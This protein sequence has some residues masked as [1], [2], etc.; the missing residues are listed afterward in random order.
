MDSNVPASEV[1]AAW[2]GYKT[3]ALKPGWEPILC[4]K[5]PLT[6]RYASTVLESGSSAL[7]IDAG[8]V[9]ERYPANLILDEES[10][11]LLGEA[12]RFFYTPKVNGKERKAG[13][14]EGLV[15][16]HPTLKPILLTMHLAKLLLPPASV[17]VRRILVPFS[18]SGSEV[19]GCLLAGW[20]EVVGVELSST[21]N[22]IAKHRIEHALQGGFDYLK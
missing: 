10:A 5:K 8:R 6:E 21:H 12:S 20:D 2:T 4:L 1:S 3:T 14:P 22:E 15:N 9:G 7:N 13:M 19:V 11:A 16:D 17:G 18:G